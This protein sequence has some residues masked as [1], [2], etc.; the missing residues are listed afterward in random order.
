[1]RRHIAALLAALTL[2]G[3]AFAQNDPNKQFAFANQLAA[4]GQA[5]FAI[6]EFERFAFL[7]PRN[8]RVPDARY[9]IARA[10]LEEGDV[11]AAKRQLADLLARYPKTNAA[12]KAKSLQALIEANSEFDHKPL[13]LFFAAAGARDR[14][15]LTRALASLD[16][17]VTRYPTAK[18]GPEALLM[19]AQVLEGLKRLDAAIAAYSELPV[20]YPNSPLI[21][22]AL[23]GQAKA[24]EARDGA[25]TNVLTLYQNVVDR[26]PGTPEAREAQARIADLRK[27]IIVLKRRYDRRDVKPF[28]VLQQGYLTRQ[29]RYEVH[30]QMPADLDDDEVK[31]TLE[32][33]L[34]KYY[35]KRRDPKHSVRILAYYAG[36]GQRA[37]YVDWTPGKKPD[38]EVDKV[39][40]REIIID[41][42]RDVLK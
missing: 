42:L 6:L 16:E 26:Y 4:R 35:D 23:L 37:G 22:R 12:A 41:I 32:D 1:M 28:K 34:L 18:L 25:K 5:R 30:I 9:A 2:L 10:W 7:F 20:R 14:G 19:R 15:D 21:P 17:L 31:A 27:R 29:T 8:P 13:L 38:Y 40:G 36:S 33:A 39:S 24:T 3:A 11:A